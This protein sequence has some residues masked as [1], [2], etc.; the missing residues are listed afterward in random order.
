VYDPGR[1]PAKVAITLWGALQRLR[2]VAAAARC[3]V[4]YVLREAFPFGPPLLERAL[5]AAAGRLVFDFDDAIY[6]PSL[7]YSNP[8]DRF[9]D[10]AKPKKVIGMA[11]R[12]V[13]GSEHLRDYALRFARS[14]EH[15][16]VI[17]TVVD[18][19]VYRPSERPAGPTLTIGWIGTPRGSSYLRDLVQAAGALCRE[20]PAVAFKFVGAEPFDTGALPVTFKPWRLDDEVG[21]LQSFDIGVMPLTD[22]EETRGKCGFKLVQYMSVG[23]PAVASPVGANRAIVEHGVSGFFAESPDDWLRWLRALVVDPGLRRRLGARGREQ[24]VLRFSRRAV[25]PSI[26]EVLRQAATDGAP[27]VARIAAKSEG[28]S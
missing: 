6:M 14:P 13:V 16:S 1:L 25:A 28:R 3:D 21:D 2:D 8:L 15:V 10:F 18:T 26:L 12:I 19:D 7:A 5:G 17:P 24:A 22:D 11:T 27:G 4:V 23:I 20:F 9:R